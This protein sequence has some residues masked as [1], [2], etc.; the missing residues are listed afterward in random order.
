MYANNAQPA[1]LAGKPLNGVQLQYS[2]EQGPFAPMVALSLMLQA[3]E[4]HLTPHIRFPNVTPIQRGSCCALAPRPLCWSL[5][6]TLQ[7]WAATK[8]Q[9]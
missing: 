9:R 7:G 6:K 4:E 1:A 2:W 5:A 8:A 3:A